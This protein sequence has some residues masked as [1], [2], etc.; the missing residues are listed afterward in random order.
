MKVLGELHEHEA[1]IFQLDDEKRLFVFLF[2][3]SSFIQG[4]LDNGHW[5]AYKAKSSLQK[6][7]GALSAFL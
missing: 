4:Y 5:R 6:E 3:L 2:V 1:T 7:A